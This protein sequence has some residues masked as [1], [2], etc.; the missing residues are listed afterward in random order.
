ML[1]F[2]IALSKHAALED[3]FE[4]SK[5][6]CQNIFKNIKRISMWCAVYSYFH[7]NCQAVSCLKTAQTAKETNAIMST[8]WKVS[9]S[10]PLTGKQIC[11]EM[12]QQQH[13]WRHRKKWSAY[14]CK[15][16]AWIKSLITAGAFLLL[17][18]TKIISE[19]QTHVSH[20]T[21]GAAHQK[22]STKCSMKQELHTH[23]SG[24]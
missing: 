14:F 20:L 17:T 4:K 19:S 15:D 2:I 9:F 24:S 16:T 11:G 23:L 5:N 22:A 8:E 10:N 1:I 18:M 3:I 12:Q 7:F 21:L 6:A 13:N